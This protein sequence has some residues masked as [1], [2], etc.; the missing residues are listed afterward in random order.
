M[1]RLDTLAA[2]WAAWATYGRTL[3]DDQWKQPTRLEPWDVRALYAHSAGWPHA[4]GFAVGQVRDDPPTYATAADLL[5][6]FNEP[7]GVAHVGRSATAEKATQDATRY[8][9]AEMT[10]AFADV[11]RRAIAVA[12]EL[13][14]VVVDYVGMGLLPLDEVVSIGIVEATVHLLD[15]QRALATTPSVPG[16]GLEHTVAVL[17]R[18]A[19][20]IDFIEAATGRTPFRPVLS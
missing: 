19:P 12:R 4:L 15:L 8:T 7:G 18:T 1:S 14:D 11:G 5:R 6:Q 13:G 2:L 3:T 16:G 10:T 9:P 20:P 17:S